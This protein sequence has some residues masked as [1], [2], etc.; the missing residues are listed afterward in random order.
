MSNSIE[1]A[2]ESFFIALFQ[3]DSRSAGKQVCHFD[4]S[5]DAQA[6]A[7]TIKCQQGNHSLAG[8][9]GYEAEVT[10]EYRASLTTDKASNDLTAAMLLSIVYDSSL[11][12]AARAAMATAAGLSDLLIKDENSSDRQNTQDLRKRSITLPIQAKLA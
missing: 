1:F 2:V 11:S 3:A 4:E 5:T 12:L 6:N 8:F 10:I 9:G 7:I